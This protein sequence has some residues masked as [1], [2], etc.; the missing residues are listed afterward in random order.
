M[1]KKNKLK[2]ILSSLAIFAPSIFGA[3][4]W[5]KL[6]EQMP[7]HWGADG[8]PDNFGGKAF[9]VF[10]IPLILL[11]INWLG[12]LVTVKDKRNENQNDKVFGIVTFI[13]PTISVFVCG[14]TY[15]IALGNTLHIF[16]FV[17][18]LLALMFLVIGNYLPKCKQNFTIGIKIKWT[19]ANEENWNATHRFVGKVWFI[20][21][22]CMLLCVFLPEKFAV[23]VAS[24]VLVTAVILPYVYSCVYY[25]KQ[26]KS[27]TAD[28]KAVVDMSPSMKRVSIVV[29]SIVAIILIACLFVTFSGN[30]VMEYGDTSV[31]I[32]ASFHEDVAFDYADVESIEFRAKDEKGIR[33][34]GFGGPRLSMGT[35]KNDEFGTYTRLSYTNCDS[36]VVLTVKGKTLVINGKDKTE[37]EK[38]YDI[39]SLKVKGVD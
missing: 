6:P 20:C 22:L 30:V 18:L 3:I 15:F 35:F 8:S 32:K 37:T 38:I 11:A 36:C 34:V 14:L 24:V 33:V 10:G 7:I 26:V 27:G 1:I 23:W 21:G 12:I 5:N 17:I 31:N 29:I 19:L 39:L 16:D 13:M 4:F 25:K 28:K 2:L 9:V